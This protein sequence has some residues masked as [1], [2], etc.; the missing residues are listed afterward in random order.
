MKSMAF[1][2]RNLPFAGTVTRWHSVNCHR[3]PSVAEHSCL[4]ALY[5]R[6]IASRVYPSLSAEDQVLLYELALMHDLSEVVTG[7]MPSPI[8]RQLKTVFPPGESPIDRLE[9][10][11]CPDAA[12]REH[13]AKSER[14]HIYFCMKLSDIL[15]AMVV[16]KQEGKGPVAKRIEHE[17][18]KAFDALL[19]RAQSECPDGEWSRAHEVREAVMSLTHVQIDEI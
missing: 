13:L 10:S 5:A 15:D 2:I 12:S 17:R 19:D 18:T 11:I 7:D 1:D 14:P 4:V 8:K 16:I 3:Y 6:E 9:A